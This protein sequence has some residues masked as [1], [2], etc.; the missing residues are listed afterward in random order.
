MLTPRCC[1]CCEP[2]PCRQCAPKQSPTTPSLDVLLRSGLSRFPEIT[3][4]WI[5]DRNGDTLYTSNTSGQ[6]PNVA[7][8]R[9]FQL[10]RDE[11]R[12][13][14]VFSEV[15]VARTTGQPGIAI[16]RALRGPDNAF[17]GAVVGAGRTG[18]P[19]EAV[20][21]ARCRPCRQCRHLPPRRFSPGAAL[22]RSAR[23]SQRAA[24]A[25]R[26]GAHGAGRQSHRHP[27][28]Q[29]RFRRRL[30]HLQLSHRRPVSLFCRRRGVARRGTGRLAAT[31]ADC[32]APPPCWYW[33]RWQPCSRA[34]GTPARIVPAS[35]PSSRPPTMRS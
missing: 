28:I 30:S 14:I 5:F 25:G 29:R 11:P 34:C 10:L 31:L 7:D 1:N 26:T 4:L 24:A 12:A 18:T 16:A 35:R 3:S 19:A 6:R 21:I 8:R 15:I 17:Y 13:G 27:F 20:Q 2:R 32:R 23:Q 22:A 33:A 9:H